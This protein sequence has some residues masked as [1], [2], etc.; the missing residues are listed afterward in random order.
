MLQISQARGHTLDLPVGVRN[1]EDGFVRWTCMPTAALV[2]LGR[3][4]WKGV[5]RWYGAVHP[6][7][8]RVSIH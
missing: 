6:S 1:A 5:P 2:A 8:L 4:D 3:D 7:V